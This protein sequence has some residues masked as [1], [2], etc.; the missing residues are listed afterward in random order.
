M[1]RMP[2]IVL[3]Q[4]HSWLEYLHVL[5]LHKAWAGVALLSSTLTKNTVTERKAGVIGTQAA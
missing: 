4:V 1:Y 2:I 5:S 3:T